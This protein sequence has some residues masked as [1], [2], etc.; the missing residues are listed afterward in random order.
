MKVRIWKT[1][2]RGTRPEIWGILSIVSGAPF[3]GTAWIT[4]LRRPGDEDSLHQSGHA[5]DL[6]TTST[7]TN[8]ELKRYLTRSLSDEYDVLLED[9]AEANEHIHIEYDP[10]G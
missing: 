8:V 10:N 5:V 9:R 1:K 2:V 4:S 3:D 7:E 6:D